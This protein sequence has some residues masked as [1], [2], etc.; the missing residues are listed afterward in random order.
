MSRV[1]NFSLSRKKRPRNFLQGLIYL[2]CVTADK[3]LI[4]NLEKTISCNRPVSLAFNK[5]D[6]SFTTQ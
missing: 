4:F 6:P 5:C 2:R 3:G 1:P